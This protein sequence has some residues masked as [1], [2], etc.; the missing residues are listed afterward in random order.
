MLF[1]TNIFTLAHHWNMWNIVLRL[2]L[3]NYFRG[4]FSRTTFW[5]IPEVTATTP[6][7]ATDP[8]C[9]N[10]DYIKWTISQRAKELYRRTF[11]GSS[12]F[13]G[14]TREKPSHRKVCIVLKEVLINI[15]DRSRFSVWP[16]L[17]GGS[18][19]CRVTGTRRFLLFFVFTRLVGLG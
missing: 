5:F 14:R 16:C 15:L 4:S 2:P 13:Y 6:T 18:I 8:R 1:L 9:E 19:N 3:I 11:C 10:T 12:V 17:Q 7:G